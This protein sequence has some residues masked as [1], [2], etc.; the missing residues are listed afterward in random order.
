MAQ[1]IGLARSAQSAQRG[2]ARRL[3]HRGQVGLRQL[4]QQLVGLGRMG[5][6]AREG[7]AKLRKRLLQR[8]QQLAPD[9]VARVALVA[10]VGSSTQAWPRAQPVAHRLPRHRQAAASAGR[11]QCAG[12]AARPA[13][14]AP[15]DRASSR[16]STWSSACC[17]SAIV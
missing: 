7:V 4:L 5:A 13:T 14:P 10:L 8:R 16:V 15:R 11:C 12:M 9:A 1:H 2:D 17:A 6:A 3:A